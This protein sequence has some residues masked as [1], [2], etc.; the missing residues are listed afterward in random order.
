MLI[1][2]VGY[3]EVTIQI[4]IHSRIYISWCVKMSPWCIFFMSIPRN[5]NQ[6]EKVIFI[7][8]LIS[9]SIMQIS[10]IRALESYSQLRNFLEWALW[11]RPLV[12]SHFQ[13][14]PHYQIFKKLSPTLMKN[15]KKCL[16]LV[17]SQ[18]NNTLWVPVQP[19][20]SPDAGTRRGGWEPLN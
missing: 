17:L 3:S 15:T 10:L 18:G 2:Y 7:W 5:T 12:P 19:A 6:G 9:C 8:C 13:S 16:P 20:I 4:P 1:R 11:M 14:K